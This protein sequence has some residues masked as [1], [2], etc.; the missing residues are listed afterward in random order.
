M[1]NSHVVFHDDDQLSKHLYPLTL[2]RPMVELR[3]GIRTIREKWLHHFNQPHSHGCRDILSKKFPLPESLENA[4][5]IN[6]CILPDQQLLS[7][8]A[9]LSENESLYADGFF[10]AKKSTTKEFQIDHG[11][12]VDYPHAIKRI[13]RPYDLFKMNAEQI[14]YDMSE[15][16]HSMKRVA[17]SS[18]NT[19]IGDESEIYLEN[20]S[21][22]EH[23]TLNTTKGPIYVG[24]NA[25]IME[26]CLVQ[27]SLAMCEGSVMKMGCKSYPGSTIG[28]YSKVGGEISNVVFQGFSNKGHDGFLGNSVLGEWCNLGAD[29]NA[30]NLSNNYGKLKVWD[31]ALDNYENSELQFCGLIMGDHSKAAI[32]MAFNTATVVGVGANIFGAGFPKKFI[33]SY[34]W[35][36][37][38]MNRT[39]LLDKVYAMAEAMMAR[40][41]QELTTADKEILE[42]IYKK[43]EVYRK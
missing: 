17:L 16:S 34:T 1:Q 33:P 20:G 22:V 11:S 42:H 18:T 19:I 38:N 15:L 40:R 10:V 14:A 35:G 3:I 23:S 37:V 43:T 32:N 5:I 30:S 26:G 21:I 29:T 39:F 36:G 28:P 31:Y 4:L 27:G 8:I 25:Q 9:N 24:K 2:T 6:G 13:K 41:G 12:K 7:A